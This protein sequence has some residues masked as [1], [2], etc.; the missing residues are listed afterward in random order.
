MLSGHPSKKARTFI[1]AGMF[2][3]AL[4]SMSLH[5]LHANSWLTE[6]AADA[7]RGLV[8]GMGIGCSGLGV[9]LLRRPPKQSC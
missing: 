6:N 5:Y 1:V 9:W 3:L 2:M 7:V 8:M 4:G